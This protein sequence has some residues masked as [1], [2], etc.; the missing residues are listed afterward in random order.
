M[1]SEKDLRDEV[2]L[3]RKHLEEDIHKKE[4][5]A[6]DKLD[7][8]LSKKKMEFCS[9]CGKKIDSRMDWGGKCLHEG[10]DQLICHECWT[11]EERRF[12]RKHLKEYVKKEEE[13]SKEGEAPE[14]K[15]DRMKRL[16]L[17]YMDF[18]KDRFDKFSC[19]DWTPHGFIGK[20]KFR[21]KNKNYGKFRIV[22]YRKGW[23]RKKPRLELLVRPIE[24]NIEG[25]INEFLERESKLHMILVLTGDTPS[26]D[27]KTK[28][29]VEKFKDKRISLFLEDLE[30]N[31]LYFN[32][33]EKMTKSY[34]SWIDPGKVPMKFKDMLAEIA[35]TMSGRKIVSAKEFSKEFG[36]E[37]GIGLK[38]LSD[39]EFLEKIKG[40]DSFILKE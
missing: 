18:L 33:E 35:E 31:K 12:C 27:I 25:M 37:K 26:I 34:S 17:S 11:S 28:K 14:I 40:T 7:E 29:F 9:R 5:E 6:E 38:I 4:L 10:C 36:L 8:L 19:M 22:V 2:E 21:I 23:V 15:M 13:V 30:M 32:P 20:V 24:E 16:T 1:A 39:C 3:A